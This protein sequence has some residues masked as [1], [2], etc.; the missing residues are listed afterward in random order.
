VRRGKHILL[1]IN[2]SSMMRK[3]TLHQLT[4]THEVTARFS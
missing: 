2:I 3:I 4:S 1:A